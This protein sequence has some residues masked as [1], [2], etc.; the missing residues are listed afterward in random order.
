MQLELLFMVTGN[1]WLKNKKF[2]KRHSFVWELENINGCNQMTKAN[3]YCYVV[4][5]LVH[6]HIQTLIF[7]LTFQRI[8]RAIVPLSVSHFG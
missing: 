8:G 3:K 7:S 2:Y 6:I 1:L 4:Y 5:V